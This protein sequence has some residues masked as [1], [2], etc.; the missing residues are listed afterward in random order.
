MARAYL[1]G[2]E[3][4]WEPKSGPECLEHH[5]HVPFA[6]DALDLPHPRSGR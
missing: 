4:E 3:Q 5:H 6:D 2:Q 1:Q